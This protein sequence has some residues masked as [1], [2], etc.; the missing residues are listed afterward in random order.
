[1]SVEHRLRT[2]LHAV[3]QSIHPDPWAALGEVETMATRHQHRT[4]IALTLAA[5]VLIAAG[6]IWGPGMIDWITGQPDLAPVDRVEVT[7]TRPPATGMFEGFP[8]GSYEGVS[9][10]T[11][12]RV[13]FGADGTCT[14]YAPD[15]GGQLDT[16]VVDGET[17]SFQRGTFSVDETTL[18]VSHRICGLGTD[19]A[20]GTEQATYTWEWDGARLIMTSEDDNCTPRK[21]LFADLVPIDLIPTPPEP[22]AQILGV[23]N[24]AQ[25]AIWSQDG[26]TILVDQL[27]IAEADDFL[28]AADAASASGGVVPLTP[29]GFAINED[30]LPEGYLDEAETVVGLHYAMTDDSGQAVSWRPDSLPSRLKLSGGYSADLQWLPHEGL[31]PEQPIQPDSENYASTFREVVLYKTDTVS[32]REIRQAGGLEWTV[33]PPDLDPY[34]SAD[35][36]PRLTLTYHY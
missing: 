8:Y 14:L 10:F 4:S 28:A 25:P 29:S 13:T 33:V 1:M 7:D 20:P 18:T 27:F 23:V 32:A 16:V 26:F 31:L 15:P 19:T 3:G 11:T 30:R 5:A 35:D 21:R 22:W 6:V 34:P 36:W 17:L 9:P 24:P 2:D 12:D